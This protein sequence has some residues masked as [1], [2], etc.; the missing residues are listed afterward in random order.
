MCTNDHLCL[1]GCAWLQRMWGCTHMVNMVNMQMVHKDIIS[2]IINTTHT[3][4]KVVDILAW[5]LYNTNLP[6]NCC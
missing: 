6:Q 2:C 4:N 3:H 1:W 5:L